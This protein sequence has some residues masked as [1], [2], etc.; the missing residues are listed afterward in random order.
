MKTTMM[1]RM[2]GWIMYRYIAGNVKNRITTMNLPPPNG[3]TAAT[4]TTTTT[5]A[6]TAITTITTTA[7]THQQN[8]KEK[9]CSRYYANAT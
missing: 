9:G 7:T 8:K 5:A 1:M 2:M 4:T 3:T 6:T